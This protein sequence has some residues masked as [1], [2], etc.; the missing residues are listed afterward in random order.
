SALKHHARNVN[1][2]MHWLRLALAY[3]SHEQVQNL[4]KV[5]ITNCPTVAELRCTY[6]LTQRMHFTSCTIPSI[7]SLYASEIWAIDRLVT[8]NR[9]SRQPTSHRIDADVMEDTH[10]EFLMID[11]LHNLLV[12]EQAA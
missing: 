3:Q 4:W 2:Y 12:T 9:L 5:A 11:L 6:A 7:R 8:V 1:L 10:K